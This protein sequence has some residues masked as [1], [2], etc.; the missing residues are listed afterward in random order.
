MVFGVL[1][2]PAE[3]RLTVVR[4]ASDPTVDLTAVVLSAGLVET[5]DPQFRDKSRMKYRTSAMLT[6][7]S[8]DSSNTEH[9]F[10]LPD[11]TLC[12]CQGALSATTT[13][14]HRFHKTKLDQYVISHKILVINQLLQKI[15]DEN[16]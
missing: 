4:A 11:L 5:N 1:V 16:V 15:S 2:F 10:S 8:R 3:K 7:P 12:S 14:G 9:S 13:S 6:L